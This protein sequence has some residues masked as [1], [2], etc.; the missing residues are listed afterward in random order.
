[1]SEPE[2]APASSYESYA[3]AV[4]PYDEIE[5]IE[6]MIPGCMIGPMGIHILHQIQISHTII[7]GGSVLDHGSEHT[8]QI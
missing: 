4:G 2:S 7:C 5:R 8:K 3:D 1:M 6:V